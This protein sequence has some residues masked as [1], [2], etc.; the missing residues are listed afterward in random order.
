MGYKKTRE[1]AIVDAKYRAIKDM[2]KNRNDEDRDD[3]NNSTIILSVL[4][5]HR[6]A[7]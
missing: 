1:A 4:Q 5:S 7:L 3:T 2:T 6:E